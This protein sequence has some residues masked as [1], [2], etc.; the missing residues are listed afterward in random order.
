MVD[1]NIGIDTVSFH[2]RA[3][4]KCCNSAPLMSVGELFHHERLFVGCL[5]LR[6]VKRHGAGDTLLAGGSHYRLS[7]EDARLL[8]DLN[9]AQLFKIGSSDRYY[10]SIMT[11]A[12]DYEALNRCPA[13]NEN[14]GC[15]IHEDRKPAV[16][17]MAPFDSLYPDSLQNIVLLSRRFDENC[18]VTG[19]PDGYQRVVANRQVADQSFRV[20]LQN[21]RDDLMREKQLWG[22]TVFQ[23]LRTELL[24]HPG[25]AAKI[26]ADDS[27]VLLSIIPVL[28]VLASLSESLRVR[29]LRYVDSQICLLDNKIAQAIAR[30]SAAD[31]Q[32]TRTFRSFKE[33]YLI[34]RPQ[35]AALKPNMPFFRA[36][37]SIEG[38]EKF[39]GV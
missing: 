10:L 34:L 12:M 38:L 30:K 8:D 15:S 16:C 1:T 19:Q 3:C 31:K 6:K 33:H 32:T 5:A 24:C 9:D 25:Q 35:L 20:A 37:R 22:D 36:D 17:S 28:Q 4:G 39:L 23:T 7:A 11:Q 14:Q 18:I 27:A 21:R 2:C 26:P 29:C 13:L